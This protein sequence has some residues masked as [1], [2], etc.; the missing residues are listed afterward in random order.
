MVVG[1]PPNLT[2][3]AVIVREPI[4]LEV[5]GIIKANAPYSELLYMQILPRN[6]WHPLSRELARMVDKYI[7]FGI[8][9]RYRLKDFRPSL[10]FPERKFNPSSNVL[11][12]MLDTDETHLNGFGNRAL[13]DGLLRPLSQ[14]WLHM[15][16]ACK[17]PNAGSKKKPK[18][19]KPKVL[20]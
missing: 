1:A 17:K 9:S 20:N 6:W 3:S 18:P 15:R 11:P 19:K 12:G 4:I 8:K 7:I 16:G 5:L 10:L 13:I 2:I 14:K